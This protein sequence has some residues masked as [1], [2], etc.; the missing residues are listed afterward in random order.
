MG[1]LAQRVD[2]DEVLIGIV[3]TNQPRKDWQLG[4][5]TVSL[6]AKNHKVRLWIKT[7]M[8]ERYWSIPALL[9]DYGLADKAMISL[10]DMKDDDMARAYSACDLTLGIGSG[11]G[12]GFPIFESIFCGT[13]CIHGY[14]AGAPEW[15][16]QTGLLVDPIAY[17]YEGLY[18]CKRPVF[19]P[20]SW[21]SRAEPILDARVNYNTALDWNNLWPHWEKWLKEGVK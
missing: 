8:A 6:L 11:E 4:I 20:Q 14:Y 2:P 9:L 16:N 21:A 12:F 13:P 15:I 10:G 18:A 7:D 5:E 3:A 19:T 1:A 17:R